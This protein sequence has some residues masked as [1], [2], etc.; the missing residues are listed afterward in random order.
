MAPACRAVAEFIGVENIWNGTVTGSDNGLFTA[1]VNGHI[2]QA[3]GYFNI[4]DA[5]DLFIRPED[6]IISITDDRTSARNRLPGTITRLS[7]VSPLVRLE[8]NCGGLPLMAV[9]TQQA[10]TDLGLVIGKHVFASM[11]ATAI[12]TAKGNCPGQ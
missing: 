10:A 4:G 5:V 1:A 2:I 11:K 7:L 12:H 3:V 6:I 9:V 8:L